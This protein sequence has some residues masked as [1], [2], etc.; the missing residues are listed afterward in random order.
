MHNCIKHNSKN[1]LNTLWYSRHFLSCLLFPFS[2]LY[3]MVIFV[4][5]L[6]YRSHVFK[7]HH[8]P[9]PVV[10]V[11]N[12]TVGGTGKTPFVIA[13]VKALQ[14]AG[15]RPGIITRGY[16]GR[17]TAWPCVVCAEDSPLLLGD[18]AVLLAQKTNV[19]VVAGPKRVEDALFL[20]EKYKVDV[21]ISDDGL[22]HYALDR[23]LEIVL[24]DE[25]RRFGNG[26]CLPA[27]PLR[28][29]QSRL[30]TVDIVVRNGVEMKFVIDDIVSL[31]NSSQSLSVDANTTVIAIAGIGNPL[32]FFESLKEK[33]LCFDEKIFPDHY[34][35]QKND[36]NKL[37]QDIIIM[38]EKDAVKC[39]DF[40]DARCYVA[41]GGAKVDDGILQN[42][43]EKIQALRA[44]TTIN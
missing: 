20:L 5:R 29:P 1:N 4:R 13:L 10:V 21:I 36:I 17:N 34:A 39:K 15:I 16:R 6:L 28:E 44:R 2:L 37:T 12:I 35:F 30:K 43:I 18:E 14:A 8:L 22:Q 27:G 32:R 33:G 40:A 25:T 23:D 24:I 38:T 7:T 11:G 3:R 19:P 31:Q 42:I 9:A 26:F 41:R